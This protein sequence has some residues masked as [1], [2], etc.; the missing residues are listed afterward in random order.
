MEAS[1]VVFS[2]LKE[3]ETIEVLYPGKIDVKELPIYVSPEFKNLELRD[4]LGICNF[5]KRCEKDLNENYKN[6]RSDCKPLGWTLFWF[7]ILFLA[8][9]IVYIVLQEWYKRN[10]ESRLFKNKN[11]LFN[12]IHFMNNSFNQGI[13]RSKIFSNLKNL[14]WRGEQL[15]YAW[16][17]LHGKRTGMWEIPIFK[18]VEKKQV[19]REL[20]KRAG[21]NFSPKDN[22]I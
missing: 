16:N 5:N 2:E 14:N 17:K 8:A 15:T 20:D 10:Y 6:C 4:E 19:K 9:F 1:V 21:A 18:W 12:L 13:R 22:R 3:A 7:F 11:H